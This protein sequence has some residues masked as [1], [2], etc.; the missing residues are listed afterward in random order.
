MPTTRNTIMNEC[1]LKDNVVYDYVS[2]ACSTTVSEY[3][4]KKD[5]NN[6]GQQLNLDDV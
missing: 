2:G 5:P 4:V 6:Q 1:K 3:F